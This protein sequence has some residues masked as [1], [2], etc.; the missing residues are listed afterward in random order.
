MEHAAASPQATSKE[1]DIMAPQLRR[2]EPEETELAG[3][4]YGLA[5][6]FVK[7]NTRRYR[8]LTRDEVL[9]AAHYGLMV[10][11]VAFSRITKGKYKFSTI[12]WLNMKRYAELARKRKARLFRRERH[13]L[14]LDLFVSRTRDGETYLAQILVLI[15]HIKPRDFEIVRLRLQG[16]NGVEIGKLYGINKSAVSSILRKH[17]RPL[18]LKG[19]I[20][21]P[22]HKKAMA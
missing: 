1:L 6:D 5:L 13:G 19:R 2:L 14:N 3:K 18:G 11:A 20:P 7:R 21:K 8:P 16:W 22:T 4:S 12:A 17:L 15:Q 10:G 9:S